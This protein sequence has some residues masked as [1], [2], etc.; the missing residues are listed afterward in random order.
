VRD[1]GTDVNINDVRAVRN[2][3]TIT[4]GSS[5]LTL[6]PLLPGS[7]NVGGNW[8]RNSVTSAFNHNNKK[9][10][11]DKQ[12]VGNQSVIIGGGLIAETFYDLEVSPASG[13]LVLSGANVNVLNE[14]RFTSGRI[15]LNGFELTLGTTGLDGNLVGG[16]TTSYLVSGS[17]TAK[18]TRYTTAVGVNYSFPMGAAG[19]YSPINVTL[20]AGTSVTANSRLTSFVVPSAHPNLGTSSN[21]LNRY[22]SLEPTGFG[23]TTH[24]GVSYVYN[25]A[26]VVGIEPNIKPFKYNTS[27]WVAA[28][29]SGASFEMGTGTVDPGT[30]TI[31]WQGLYT[32]SDFTGNGNGT[33]LPITLLDFDAQPVIDHV[34]V[35]WTTAAEINNDFFTVE[36]SIDGFSFQ[37]IGTL[38][39]AGNSN[40]VKHYV[41]P[42][43]NPVSGLNY[44]RLKQTDFDGKSSYS[45]IRVVNFNRSVAASSELFSV[46]PNPSSGNAINIRAGAINSGRVEVRLTDMLGKLISVQSMNMNAESNAELNFGDLERGIY[47]LTISG[48]GHQI[49]VPVVFVR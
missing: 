11:F 33:P 43:M 30:N 13:D 21:Y 17:T 36:R 46:Y 31:D 25:D 35:S 8:T 22:W 19:S 41:L 49:V 47:H 18:F 4:S 42:D 37:V 9:V 6:N 38:D 48:S 12:G 7:F 44:Y 26:D 3:I 1:N 14:L 45:D 23:T 27:G 5:S 29:G 32:F 40:A 2:D 15:N 24:Y 28:T 20:Y 16:G 34:Q 10:V 39:G